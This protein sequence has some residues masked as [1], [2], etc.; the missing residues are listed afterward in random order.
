MPAIWVRNPTLAAIDLYFIEI[1]VFTFAL[2]LGAA[3]ALLIGDAYARRSRLPRDLFWNAALVATLAGLA[4]ARLY[5]VLMHQDYYAANPDQILNFAQGGLGW[6]GGVMAGIIALALY[7][8]AI[9]RS[10]ARS[11]I[12]QL[13]DAIALGL[14]PAL[15][16]GWLGAHARG[17]YYGAVSDA[18][19]AQVLPDEFG[20]FDL[21]FPIQLTLAIWFALVWLWLLW[22]MPRDPIPGR[23]V[24]L[25]LGAGAT[26]NFLLSF[27][28]GDPTWMWNNLRFDQYMDAA[29]F[30]GSVIVFITRRTRPMLDVRT[31]EFKQVP[32]SPSP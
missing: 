24:A 25:F 21:R 22:E 32:P 29:I 8:I 7:G 11:R 14:A 30:I 31:I 28:R 12:W 19:V 9:R 20:V 23:I 5:H 15:T 18:P 2:V 16:I 17:L 1:P 4:G 10:G 6:R 26:G 27:W 13:L 3:L